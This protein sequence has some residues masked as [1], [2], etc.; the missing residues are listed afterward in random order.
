LESGSGGDDYKL[1]GTD[2]DFATGMPLG[3]ARTGGPVV[4][5][6]IIVIHGIPYTVQVVTDGTTLTVGPYP[7]AN[8]PG[9]EDWFIVRSDTIRAPQAYNSVMAVGS[10]P[11][12][13]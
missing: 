12:E 5:G 1:T 11:W 9:T 7:A 3:G 4:P 6:D 8:V 2:T 10:L 13:S